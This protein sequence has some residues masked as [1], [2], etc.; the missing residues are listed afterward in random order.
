MAFPFHAV[1]FDMDGTLT[2]N[3]QWHDLAWQQFTRRH[4]GLDLPLGDERFH[5]GT[6]VQVLET[7][8]GR[9]LPEEE[10]IA[11]HDLK[12]STYR[13][14]AQG[15]L[16]L[17]PGLPDYLR[18]L[19]DLRVPCALVTNAVGDNLPFT[20]A[21]LGLEQAFDVIVDGSM[22][23]RAKPHPD[24]YLH[25]CEQLGVEPWE[26]LVHEDSS[27]GIHAGRAASCRVAAMT[28]SLSEEEALQLGANWACADFDGWI[29]RVVWSSW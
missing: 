29:R 24:M 20:L 10:A 11:L 26:C 5:G 15:Q 1:L 25:A 23:A 2:D 19:E 4:L 27:V 6:T 28:T 7:L 13:D 8:L 14:L 17:L 12:E 22:C 3:R 21:Q 16:Q 9:P 18:R